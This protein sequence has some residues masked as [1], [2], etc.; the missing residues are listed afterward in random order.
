[1]QSLRLFLFYAIRFILLKSMRFIFLP[2]MLLVWAQAPVG[3]S[4]T[5]PA[6][7]GIK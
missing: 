6:K 3:W 2:Q 5:L 7:A 1:M 4:F